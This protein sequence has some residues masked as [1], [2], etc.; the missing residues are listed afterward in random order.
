MIAVETE[1]ARL[2]GLALFSMTVSAMVLFFA[3]F[4]G[5]GRHVRRGAAFWMAYGIVGSYA[6]ALAASA[7]MLWFF[8][9]F[10]GASPGVVV[11]QTVVLAFPAS[12]GASAGRLLIQ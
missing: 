7:L 8:G 10:G 5:A 11:E 2:I 6:I 12:L 1:P 9:R 4:V 3:G